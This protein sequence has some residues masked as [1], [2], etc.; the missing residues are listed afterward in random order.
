MPEY[1]GYHGTHLRYARGIV[2]AGFQDSRENEWLGR[3]VY[4]FGSDGNID[5]FGEAKSWS[6]YVKRFS[7]WAVLKALLVAD[8]S[9]DMV[10]NIWI[11][12]IIYSIESFLIKLRKVAMSVIYETADVQLIFLTI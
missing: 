3:G 4:F 2:Q 6:V 10:Y 5:G 1:L 9:L 11:W 8:K 7:A 12:C